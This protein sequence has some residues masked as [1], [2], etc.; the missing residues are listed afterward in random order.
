MSKRLQV[1]VKV[2]TKPYFEPAAIGV[3]QRKCAC[4]NHAMGECEECKE[5]K[6]IKG[7]LQRASVSPR[8]KEIEGEVPSTVHEVLRSPGQPLDAE[9]RAFMEPRFGHD[10]SGVRV[11]TDAKAAE[12]ARAVNALAYTVQR[13]VVFGLGLYAPTTDA[14]RRLLAHELTHTIQH[15]PSQGSQLVLTDSPVHD[16]PVHE[17]EANAAAQDVLN[18]RSVPFL[19]SLNSGSISRQEL[20]PDEP[21]KIERDFEVQPHVF[22]MNPAAEKEVEKRGD[23]ELRH[24]ATL[25]HL[26]L[27]QWRALTQSERDQVLRYMML[28]YGPPFAS[29]FLVYAKGIKKPRPGPGGALKG[30][31]YTPK[32]LFGRGY[33]HAHGEIWVHP[34]GEWIQVFEPSVKVPEKEPSPPPEGDIEKTCP[35]DKCFDEEGEDS[36]KDCCEELYPDKSSECR[37]YCDARCE[38]LL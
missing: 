25:P 21:L 24:L 9:T 34:S 15:R 29:E 35:S 13:H 12:S 6:M 3:L 28:L 26:A 1:Q 22:P 32:W 30:F 38:S 11:H 4:G 27:K 37:R 18:Q 16:S 31:E 10:F 19:T 33:R 23:A 5:S 7:L 14:G 2:A 8:G 20:N 36:C 17:R